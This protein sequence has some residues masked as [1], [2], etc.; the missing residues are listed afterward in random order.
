MTSDIKICSG[1][2]DAR[3]ALY[4]HRVVQVGVGRSLDVDVAGD[5]DVGDRNV[6][7]RRL[8]DGLD[9]LLV[10]VHGFEGEILETVEAR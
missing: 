7:P 6:L 8:D 3:Q 9:V 1:R 10:E 4:Q 5:G 2:A